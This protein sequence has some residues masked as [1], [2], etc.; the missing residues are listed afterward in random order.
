MSL[1]SSDFSE[2]NS[3]GHRLRKPLHSQIL[4][5]NWTMGS[6]NLLQEGTGQ[7][8]AGLLDSSRVEDWARRES[9]EEV[10]HRGW[11]ES[12]FTLSLRETVASAKTGAEQKPEICLTDRYCYTSEPR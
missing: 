7:Y 6:C 11:G 2:F 1:G 5:S 12:G 4:T 9:K 3:S 10:M 8:Q